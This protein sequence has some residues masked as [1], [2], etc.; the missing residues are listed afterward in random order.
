MS[1]KSVLSERARTALTASPHCCT[2]V[3]PILYSICLIGILLCPSTS[4][5]RDAFHP[6]VCLCVAVF[7]SFVQG[8]MRSV[9]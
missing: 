2:E 7:F 6:V 4:A 8:W 3:L 9:G 1:V 5:R